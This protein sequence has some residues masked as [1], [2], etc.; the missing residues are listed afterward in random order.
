MKRIFT[1]IFL[2]G[3]LS[4]CGDGF[5][6]EDG[7]YVVWID[8]YSGYGLYITE[9]REGLLGRVRAN[10]IAVGSNNLYVVARQKDP[11]T[12]IISYFYIE[13][14]K[15]TKYLNQDEITQGPFNKNEFIKLKKELGLPAFSKQ[16]KP[17][18]SD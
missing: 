12:K 14:A 17:Y 9:D 5:V 18:N 13:K 6:W 16:F 1:I 10:V 3:I 15:D 7:Q 8:D 11:K 4:G 2:C